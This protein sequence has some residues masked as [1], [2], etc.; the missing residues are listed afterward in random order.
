MGGGEIKTTLSRVERSNKPHKPRKPRRPVL[1]ASDVGAD[2]R[3][4]PLRGKGR[5]GGPPQRL[6]W[7]R[8]VIIANPRIEIDL[9]F[10]DQTIHLL[11]EREPDPT[12]ITKEKHTFECEECGLVRAFT[13][14]LPERR[15]EAHA[16]RRQ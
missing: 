11:S 7:P 10:I 6:M 2:A 12:T 9:Q 1:I 4:S 15:N 16:R 8:L 5:V 14:E 3:R 13:I